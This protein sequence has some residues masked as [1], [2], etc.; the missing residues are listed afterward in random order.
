LKL[1][2]EVVRYLWG[3]ELEVV[4]NKGL[5]VKGSFEQRA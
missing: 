5:E 3:K 1:R 4:S 2:G